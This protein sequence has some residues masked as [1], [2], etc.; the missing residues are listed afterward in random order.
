MGLSCSSK[1]KPPK[2]SQQPKSTAAPVK[3]K[4]KLDPKDY[5]LSQLTGEAITKRSGSIGGEQF[6]IE[7]C[8]D[9]DIFLCDTIATIFVDD[10]VSCRIF[11]GPVESS[12][13]LRNCKDCNFVI[14]C[15][16]FRCRDCTNC[17]VGLMS[18]TE[19]VIETSSQMK[20]ACFD[21]FYFGLKAH[22]DQVNL[23]IFN[24]KWWQIH[25]FNKN[26][27]NPNWSLLPQDQ[28]PNGIL[29]VDACDLVNSE[30]VSLDR[31]VPITLGCRPWP[32]QESC[33]VVFLPGSAEYIEAFM[34]KVV[35]TETWSLC[36]SR[37]TVLSDERLKALFAAF[38]KE[39]LNARCKD[40]EVT[41][42]EICGRAVHREVRE[43]LDNT[44]L[45]AGSKNIRLIPEDS[46]K[47]L[48]KSFF[49]TWKDEI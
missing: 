42:I 23:N 24:N 46:S 34:A 20:F 10:C 48:A 3:V 44:G 47:V 43:A 18:N 8:T 12:I 11:V 1:S 17:N 39:K 26:E 19:P 16:Q 25:D 45:A 6:N 36:R 32:S 4:K 7:N 38:L 5:V 27:A 30:E 21:F 15:Q 35:S 22:F 2:E 14:A 9:C 31:V 28:V 29:R 33:F 40:K 13:F 37:A 49:D 41:G